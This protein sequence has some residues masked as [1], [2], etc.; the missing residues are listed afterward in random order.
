MK[1]GWNAELSS[2]MRMLAVQGGEIQPKTAVLYGNGWKLGSLRFYVWLCS[3]SGNGSSYFDNSC[4]DSSGALNGQF[5]LHVGEL[6]LE[7]RAQI[8]KTVNQQQSAGQ[9]FIG[10][11]V[12]PRFQSDVSLLDHGDHGLQ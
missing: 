11:F 12:K 6:S 9:L 3:V 10:M 2:M 7:L 4:E 1:S 8:G 5:F